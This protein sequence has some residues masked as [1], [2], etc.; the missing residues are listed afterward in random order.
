MSGVRKERFKPVLANGAGTFSV[1][2]CTASMASFCRDTLLPLPPKLVENLTNLE[3]A[4][5]AELKPE[6]WILDHEEEENQQAKCCHIPS[7]RR[8]PVRDTL[9]YIGTVFR[10]LCKCAGTV[11]LDKIISQWI[12]YMCTIIH[13]EKTSRTMFGKATI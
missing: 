10:L 1:H 5:M 13:I 3:F 12:M 11:L 8:T 6:S 9:S 2:T 4:D 7:R